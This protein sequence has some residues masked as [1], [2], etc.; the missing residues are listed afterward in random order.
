M[1]KLINRR[2]FLRLSALTAVGTAAA[3]CGAQATP[4]PKPA[5]TAAPAAKAPEPTKAP[6]AAAPTAAPKAAEPT[7]APAAAAPASQYKE[8]PMLADLVKGGKLPAVD[9]RLPKKPAVFKGT[10]GVGKYGG[11]W[12]RAFNGVSDRWG[13]TKLGD[14]TWAWFDKK[15][16]PAAAPGRI[17]AGQPRRQ[18]VDLQ[19]ARGAQVVGRQGLH[20]RRYRLVVQDTSYRI[21]KCIPACPR[22]LTNKDK[23]FASSMCRT[24]TPSSSRSPSPK[25]LLIYTLTRGS[26]DSAQARRVPATI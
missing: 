11:T 6:A 15:L 8:A 22:N 20:H 18:R 1:K 13:P 3:A 25:P 2:E 21:R 17:V 23:S 24:S 7:K 19:D 16:E 14:R 10:E 5:P 26:V 4:A 12:R 9:A